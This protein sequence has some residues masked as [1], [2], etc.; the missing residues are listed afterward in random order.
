MQSQF[1]YDYLVVGAGLFGAVFANLACKAGRKCL[2]IDKR[3]HIGGNIYTHEV[4]GIPV[5]EYG[6]HIFHTSNEAVWKFVNQFSTFN[7][8]VNSPIANYKGRLFNLPFNMNTFY[9]IWGGVKTPAEALAKIEAQRASAGIESPQNLEEQAISLV[10]TDIYE[11][12]IKGYTEKQWG[13]DCKDLPPSIIKRLPVRLTFDNNYFN[14]RYQGIPEEGYTRLVAKLL[15][16]SEVR[17]NTDFLL[18]KEYLSSLARKVIF[19]G[20]IDAFFENCFGPLEYRT[21]RF[22][23]EVLP[24][25]NY[26]GVAVVNYTE[27]EVPYTR[28][29]EHKHF[30][31]GA[32]GNPEK[33]VISREYPEDWDTTKEPYYPVND[34]K[35][36]RLYAQ[37]AE[38]AQSRPDAQKVIFGGRLG[39]Y[40]YYDMDKVIESALDM[41]KKE[42]L[43]CDLDF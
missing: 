24:T 8:F 5:H 9:A 43:I 36:A 28:I 30:V 38:L 15:E 13:R 35:N 31:F 22:E 3:S 10:G 16:G 6:A 32:L 29:I 14:A 34:E 2:V 25:A 27:R 40:R 42:G 7:N 4:E 33:T 39:A 23:T 17:L 1:N 41:A 21:V 18:D 11:T 37:Y 12:L 19:T 26:Q 20:P